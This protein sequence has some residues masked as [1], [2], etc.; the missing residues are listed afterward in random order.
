MKNLIQICLALSCIFLSGYSD[1]QIISTY[2][3]DTTNGYSGDGFA[4]TNAQ[5]KQPTGIAADWNGNIFIADMAANCVRKVDKHG[6]IT[7]LAGTGVAGYNGDSIA[8]N[9]AQLSS[10]RA[11]ACDR[12]GNVYIGDD[13]EKIRKVDT[14]GIITTIYDGAIVYDGSIDNLYPQTITVDWAGNLYFGYNYTIYKY[15]PTGHPTLLIAAGTGLQCPSGLTT[16]SLGHL[17]VAN[18][19]GNS[20][21]VFLVDGTDSLTLLAGG[22]SCGSRGS[23]CYTSAVGLGAGFFGFTGIVLDD[24]GNKYFAQ[25]TSSTIV[26]M[27]TAGLC[28]TFAGMCNTFGHSG[29]GGPANAAII[30]IGFSANNYNSLAIDREGNIYFVEASAHAVRKITMHNDT[31]HVSTSISESK[32]RNEYGIEL[33]PVPCDGNCDVNV[34]SPITEMAEVVITNSLGQRVKEI[35]LATNSTQNIHFN[36]PS[37][38]YFISAVT[39]NGK[40]TSKFI[41]Q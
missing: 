29:D 25:C 31:T 40:Y 17:Y 33:Y 18:G 35:D 14:N 28:S 19:T 3:G 20:G 22:G 12:F 23:G 37:G 26:K 8:A 9:T 6:I 21:E 34:S 27:D 7:T 13:F 39:S 38:I 5:L 16:D 2:A 1:A 32:I 11:V 41:M 10:P 36:A 15:N 24:S 30:S 4:A